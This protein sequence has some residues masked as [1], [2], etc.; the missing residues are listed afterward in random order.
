MC[1]RSAA[2]VVEPP[3][4]GSKKQREAAKTDLKKK[5]VLHHIAAAVLQMFCR[6]VADVM[7]CATNL[8][9]VCCC[10]W[11]GAIT[12]RCVA[13]PPVVLHLRHTEETSKKL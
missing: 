2:N 13:S 7:R 9:Q 5:S 6:Y 4:E 11:S 10:S 3:S 8:L 1:C 12:P